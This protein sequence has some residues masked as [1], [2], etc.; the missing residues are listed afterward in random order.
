MS[1][2]ARFLS[3]ALLVFAGITI[4]VLDVGKVSGRQA[5][6]AAIGAATDPAR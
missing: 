5:T 2:V 1:K 3:L 4:I 6:N